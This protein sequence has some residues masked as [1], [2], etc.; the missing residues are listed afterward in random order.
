MRQFHDNEGEVVDLRDYRQAST[1]RG[2]AVIED[3][4]DSV[5][6][7]R[8]VPTR[9]EIDP[10]GLRGAL[11]NAFILERVGTGL[12]RFRIAGSH[13][14]SLVDTELRGMPLSAIFE[15]EARVLLADALAAV[16]DEPAIARFTLESRSGFGRPGLTGEMVLLP[17]RSD[18]GDVTRVLGGLAVDGTVGRTPRRLGIV[19]QSRKTLTGYAGDGAQPDFSDAAPEPVHRRAFPKRPDRVALRRTA[20]G[21]ALRLVIDNTR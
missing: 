1:L 5:R 16:F 14:V 21:A 19:G 20:N 13:L 12:A 3:Y 7:S 18:L 8:L 17:L 11:E 6:R 10:R 2:V 4:W 15:P 9:A